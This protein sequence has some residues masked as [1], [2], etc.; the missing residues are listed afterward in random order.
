TV[1]SAKPF[2]AEAK[3]VIADLRPFVDD[4]EP[5]FDDLVP[6]SRSLTKDS[7]T[8]VTYMSN[9]Q[10]FVYNTRSVFGAGDGPQKD[11]IRGHFVC[12]VP[13]CAGVLPGNAGGFAPGPRDGTEGINR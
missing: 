11:I 2:V 10:A 12:R 7:Q 4:A 9:I 3:P 6:V 8:L 1:K 13:D 5:A